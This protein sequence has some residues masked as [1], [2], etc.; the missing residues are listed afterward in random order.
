MNVR[1]RQFTRTWS[2]APGRI[3]TSLC[4]GVLAALSFVAMAAQ[5]A[6]AQEIVLYSADVNTISGNWARV[7]SATGAGVKKMASTDL[8]WSAVD[9]PLASPNDYFE[10]TFNARA[11]IGYR[12][13]LRMKAAGNSKWNDAVWVQFSDSLNASGNAIYRIGTTSGLLVNLEQCSGCGMSNWGWSGGAWWLSQA[14]AIE[15]ASDGAKT[16]RIQTREDGVEIDQIVISQT[17]YMNGSPGASRDDTTILARSNPA[18]TT[19]PPSSPPPTGAKALPGIIQAEDFDNGLNQIAYWDSTAGNYG[20]QYRT[21]DVD[22]EGCAE[23]GYNIGWITGGEWLNYTVNVASA[24]TY[25]LDFR[26]AS[27]AGGTLHVEFNG[28]DKTGSVTVPATGGWQS[29]TTV[30]RTVTLS[31][32]AQVM[33]VVFDTGGINI[34]SVGASSGGSTSAPSQP[35]GAFGGT[36]RALPGTVEAEDFDQGAGVGFYDTTAGNSGGAYRPTTDVDIEPASEG[37]YNIGWIAGGEW[38]SYTVNVASAGTY[39]LQLRVASHAGG[40]AHVEFNGQ[41]KTGS[42]SI[43]ATGGWQSW[44]TVSKSVTLSGGTQ[45]MR[46]VF[47]TGGINLNWIRASSGGSSAPPPPPSAGGPYGGTPGTFPG[48]VQVE[49]FDEGGAGL[50]YYDT[51]AGNSG[52]AYRA[53]DVDIEATA[54]GGFAVGWATAGEWLRYTVNVTTAGNYRLVARVA[55]AGTGGTFHVEFNGT[56]RTGAMRIPSTGAWSAYTDAVATVWLD[57]GVQPM[58]IV[59]D[60]N[61]PTNTVGNLSYIRVETG[62]APAPPPPPPPPPPAAGGRLRVATWNIKFGNGNPAGQAQEIANTGAD[63]IVL[64][65]GSTYD[66][67]MPTTYPARLRQI[68]GQTWYSHWAGAPVCPS[69]CQGLLILSR[70]PIVDASTAV[71]GGSSFARIL[72]D[73][74]GVRVNIFDAHLDYFDTGRRTTQ[75]NDLMNWSRSFGGP[76]IVGGDFNSWWGEWWIGQME[77][78]YTDTWQDVTGGDGNGYTLN[79]TVRFDYLFRAKDQSWRLTPTACWTHWTSLSDHIPVVAD[80]QVK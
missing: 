77:T 14:L 70:L 80:Y 75:L 29:W 46:V 45:G 26:V 11:R 30:S 23:G 79:G 8:G 10:A 5:P 76:R 44:T 69:G 58:R 65:E 34:N 72:V 71:L 52:G 66:E 31:S 42:I 37:T 41:D 61:G 48:T 27:H 51:S 38:L 62:S 4:A 56:D 54:T 9:A 16:I 60:A 50:A 78:E 19:T 68:T 53:T 3:S 73:V 15:F 22:V 1:M 39:T 20:G 18:V 49:D 67:D 21:T 40:T 7:D 6:A 47:D 35:G 25:T 2:Q 13:W 59:L 17:T 24:G 33:R 43:P 63:V 55:S 28:Q 57:A 74:G 36:A 32:G 64:Q 12:V